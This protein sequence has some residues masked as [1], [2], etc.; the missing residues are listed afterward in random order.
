MSTSGFSVSDRIRS[1]SYAANGLKVLWKE[2][3]NSRIQFVA[4]VIA[5]AGGFLLRISSAEWLAI[6]SVVGL[7]LITEILNSA[8]ENIADFVSP[9]RNDAI[10]RIKDLSAA[11]VLVAALTSLVVGAIVF[12]PKLIAIWL[13]C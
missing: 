10:K 4:A 12:I 8:V 5:I 11:A 2:E 1:F 13:E 7:V 3:H 6:I 9:E